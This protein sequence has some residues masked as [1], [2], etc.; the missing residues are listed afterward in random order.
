MHSVQTDSGIRFSGIYTG[1]AV[2]NDI[3]YFNTDQAIYSYNP[4][5]DKEPVKIK[6]IVGVCGLF[7]HNNVLKYNKCEPEEARDPDT[8]ELV[9]YY[10]HFRPNGEIKLS[11]TRF[12]CPRYENGRIVVRVYKED[13]SPLC[14]YSSGDTIDVK[15]V[16]KSN[17][18]KVYFDVEDEQTIFF[19]N[20][21]MQ[22]LTEKK[23]HKNN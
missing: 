3:L 7:I 10:L 18:S 21:K 1:L 6:D 22:P 5:K 14:I 19:W 11:N 20:E 12:G 17:V 13:N 9:G 15:T 2:H 23:L 16:R 8:N 4:K